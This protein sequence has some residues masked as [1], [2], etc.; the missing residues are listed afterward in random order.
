MAK[1]NSAGYELTKGIIK[2]NPLLILMLGTCPALAVTTSAM[3]GLGMGAASTIVLI[4]SNVVISLLRK[5]IP[6]RIR[7]PAYIT[8]IASLVTILQFLLQAYLPELDRSLGIFIPLI[9]V[10]CIILGRAEAFA[11]SHSVFM[12]AVDGLGMGVGFSLALFFI[13][14]LRE[15]LGFGT[16]F[17]IPMPWISENGLQPMMIFGLPAGGFAIFGIMVALTQKLSKKYYA[18]RPQATMDRQTY[19]GSISQR[20]DVIFE[21]TEVVDGPRVARTPAR[22]AVPA[23]LTEPGVLSKPEPAAESEDKK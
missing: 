1:K 16:L 7:I 9:T 22:D 10:N 12:S 11:S 19:P 15:I 20:T 3:N 14:S 18:Q 2:E 21:E 17:D 8:I 4:L 13:G 6:D 5:V 23:P